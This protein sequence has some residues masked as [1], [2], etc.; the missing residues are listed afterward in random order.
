[1]ASKR[2]QAVAVV[3]KGGEAGRG[4]GVKGGGGGGDDQKQRI[5]RRGTE[6]QSFA[7]LVTDWSDAENFVEVSFNSD[8]KNLPR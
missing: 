7:N 5:Q 6:K 2:E 3:G 1:M 8:A 4:E